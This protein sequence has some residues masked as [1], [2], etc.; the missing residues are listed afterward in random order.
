MVKVVSLLS[1]GIDSPVA[2]YLLSEAGA[3]VIL[4]NLDPGPFSSKKTKRIVNDLVKKLKR[5]DP[6][7]RAYRA[8]SSKIQ[9]SI[10]Q[11]VNSHYRCLICRRMMFR[12][13]DKLVKEIGAAAIATGE[14]LGQVASQTLSN[15]AS[16]DEVISTPIL[17]PLIGLDKTEIISIARE[18]DTYE[19]STRP[20]ICCLL[21]PEKPR[22]KSRVKRVKE[23]ENK[24]NV[25]RLIDA[26]DFKEI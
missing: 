24:L 11:N 15:I 13:A 16:E 19:I 18:I 20:S 6:K 17:R 12:T 5:I 7:I 9:E 23:E 3:E 14:S 4:L 1:G 22:V 21:T 2:S 8:E 10:A 26:L 25:N